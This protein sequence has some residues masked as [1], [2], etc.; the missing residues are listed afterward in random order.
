MPK[1]PTIG[2]KAG[3]SPDGGLGIEREVSPT[4]AAQPS[5]LEPT[6]CHPWGVGKG[7]ETIIG[8][9][10][11]TERLGN[12]WWPEVSFTLQTAGGDATPT[13]IDRRRP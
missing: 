1:F 12:A 11:T 4:L 6:V 9:I 7:R 10:G 5:A 8:Q 2:F 3:Q 13:I